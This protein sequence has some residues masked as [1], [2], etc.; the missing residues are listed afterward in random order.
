ME[1]EQTK[2]NEELKSNLYRKKLNK[3]VSKVGQYRKFCTGSLTI[4][5]NQ[6]WNSSI[7]KGLS[8]NNFSKVQ[9]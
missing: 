6:K 8:K 1:I 4:N 9:K 2:T 5:D 3:M 7:L